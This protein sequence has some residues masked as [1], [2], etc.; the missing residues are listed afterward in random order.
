MPRATRSTPANRSP[1]RA[2]PAQDAAESALSSSNSPRKRARPDASLDMP[3]ALDSLEHKDTE[4]KVASAPRKTRRTGR[5]TE[6]GEASVGQA[7]GGDSRDASTGEDGSPLRS[8]RSGAAMVTEDEPAAVAEGGSQASS[9][10]LE[11]AQ[12]GEVMFDGPDMSAEQRRKAKGKGKATDEDHV[13][14][15][16]EGEEDELTRLRRELAASKEVRSSD[17]SHTR[18]ITR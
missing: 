2:T 15:E 14:M 13:K 17:S 4:G 1:T 12:N 3:D 16:D 11:Q 9:S 6:E 7:G 10:T 5:A 18:S 8:T